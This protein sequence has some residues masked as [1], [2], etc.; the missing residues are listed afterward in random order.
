[1][2]RPLRKKFYV[3]EHWRPDKDECF[4]VG[5][6]HGT[7]AFNIHLRVRYKRNRHY[8]AVVNKLSRLGMC[9]EVRMI[10]SS[11]GEHEAFALKKVRIAFWRSR[12][13]KL[14]NQ[15]DG[16]DGAS[17]YKFRGKKL[18]RLRE[19]HRTPEAREA[20]RQRMLGREVKDETRNKIRQ[21]RLGSHHTDKTRR[22][23]RRIVTG[24]KVTWGNKISAGLLGHIPS[25]E[26][27]ALWRSQRKGK[28]R[29]PRSESTKSKISATL[30]GHPVSEEQRQKQS[31]T[32]LSKPA[33]QRHANAVRA[34]TSRPPEE[35]SRVARERQM[36]K[37]PEQRR[38]SAAKGVETRRR[39]G[40]FPKRIG[41]MIP[42]LNC[43]TEFYVA[44]WNANRRYCGNKCRGEHLLLG[45]KQSPE[46]VAKRAK[47]ISVAKRRIK[48]PV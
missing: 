31:A 29:S 17:G 34:A 38:S 8:V 41:R 46:F 3:Y 42:C 7:R 32:M 23:L 19:A 13:V 16:G 2:K 1:M 36:A 28:K 18:K 48:E 14:T 45:K 35:R 33:E 11:L 22:K 5:K 25:E 21:I 44:N 6:G 27:R 24:R 47:A 4:Y 43:S 30:L 15:T 39:N 12:G 9:V 20:Q 37:T 40:F 26:T 10:E